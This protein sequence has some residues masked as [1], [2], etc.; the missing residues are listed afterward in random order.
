MYPKYFGINSTLFD[1]FDFHSIHLPYNIY[2]KEYFAS[3]IYQHDLYFK[4]IHCFAFIHLQNYS[5]MHISFMTPYLDF[6]I[7][8]NFH[9]SNINP[10]HFIV[11]PHL[12]LQ[13]L[14][15]VLWK[16]F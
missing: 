6:L 2:L 13:D 1:C 12:T 4:S 15:S 3:I 14:F 11:S 5:S 10:K 16:F 8:L 9:F 7:G